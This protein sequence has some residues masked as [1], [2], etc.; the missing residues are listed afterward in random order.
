MKLKKR[1]RRTLIL[2]FVVLVGVVVPFIPPLAVIE[3]FFLIIPFAVV[4]ISTLIFLIVSLRSSTIKTEKAL[5]T[6]SILP[7]F[8]ISQ[9]VA[10]VAVDKVQRFR[11]EG[12]IMEIH[13]IRNSLGEAPVSYDTSLGIAYRR[14][15]DKNHYV[16]SYSRGFMVTEEFDSERSTWKSYGW[17]D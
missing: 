15:R 3:V 11:S 13:Q 8:I 10:G 2:L 16:I 9:L 5:F 14:L 12:I 6:F 1:Q 4:F 7:T 17:N